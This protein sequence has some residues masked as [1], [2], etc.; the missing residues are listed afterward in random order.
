MKERQLKKKLHGLLLENDLEFVLDQI[1]LY[2]GKQMISPLI[3]FLYHS[4]EKIKWH[5]VTI[6]GQVMKS[7]AA[8]DKEE[9]RLVMRRLLWNLNEE[10]GGIGW[11]M[12]EA[13]GEIMAETKWLAEEYSNM[14]VS[15][16]REENYLELP[17]LQRGLMW[18]VGRLALL[19]PDLLLKYDADGYMEHYLE[20]EDQEILALTSRNFGILGINK[21]ICYK[22]SFRFLFH[23]FSHLFNRT[24]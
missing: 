11:G 24:G 12:P 5:S 14:L 7:L 13:L 20:S 15:Y 1:A 8:V 22:I 2:P 23:D 10:S 18:G 6:I 19:R 17:A 16:M 9:A 3:S 4:D 21:L